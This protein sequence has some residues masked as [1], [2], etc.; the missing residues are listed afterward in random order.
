MAIAYS[1]GR[2]RPACSEVFDPITRVSRDLKI[3]ELRSEIKPFIILVA[4]HFLGAGI[5]PRSFGLFAP[6]LWR[7][8]KPLL[9]VLIASLFVQIFALVSPCS[10]R[11]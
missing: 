7:Y 1:A 3:S 2:R 6:S 9:H 8:R 4:R 11:W 5:D 10:S